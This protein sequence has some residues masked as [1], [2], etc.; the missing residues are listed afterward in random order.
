M[1]PAS[2]FGFG[3]GDGGIPPE[4]VQPVFN[5]AEISPPVASDFSFDPDPLD[6]N[7]AFSVAITGTNFTNVS[8][9]KPNRI[10]VRRNSD[11]LIVAGTLS[12]Y[13][14]TSIDGSFGT[15]VEPGTYRVRVHFSDG[16]T[17]DAGAIPVGDVAA[18]ISGVVLTPT[19]P[20]DGEAFTAVISG[21]G[22]TN[23]RNPTDVIAVNE[24]TLA[25]T[26]GTI[27][28]SPTDST[29]NASFGSGL[30]PDDTYHLRVE[31]D[32]A[33]SADSDPFDIDPLPTIS[34][35]VLAPTQPYDGQAFTVQI[36]GAAFTV[37]DRAP[38][39]VIA[40]NTN[41]LAETAGVITGSPTNTNIDASFASG[42]TPDD[43]YKFR[44]E[45]DD[46]TT[47]ES[48]TFD[49]YALPVI[50]TATSPLTLPS[51]FVIAVTGT[52]FTL[53]GRAPSTATLVGHDGTGESPVF[54]TVT[55]TSFNVTLSYSADPSANT[56]TLRVTWD[57]GSVA[58]KTGI[59]VQT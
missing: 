53:N 31:F 2:F 40:V 18:S 47:V 35:F 24:D 32:D 43:T 39:D 16:A 46:T 59:V 17:L 1:S 10:E 37:G 4:S 41:T 13:T 45:F 48:G 42:L 19:E 34:G 6:E 15:S 30:T 25:E 55:D 14:G 58:D 44:V 52:D 54:D 8:G 38:S 36:T 28:G 11:A 3:A 50:A 49:I 26:A 12:A 29:I 51:P 27:T 9:R 20:Y 7:V 57:D 22:F 23:D 21:T 33:T 5:P 56:Y